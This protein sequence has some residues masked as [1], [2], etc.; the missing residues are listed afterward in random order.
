MGKFD[1]S[2]GLC[3]AIFKIMLWNLS[4]G[5]KCVRGYNNFDLIVKF[6][7]YQNVLRYMI[8]FIFIKM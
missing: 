7:I 5:V 6:Y 3:L 4:H 1:L 8:Y 2:S